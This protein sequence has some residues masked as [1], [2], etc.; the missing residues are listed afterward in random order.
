MPTAQPH[1]KSCMRCIERHFGLWPCS[2]LEKYRIAFIGKETGW[3]GCPFMPNAGEVK[4][5]LNG[6]PAPIEPEAKQRLT[7]LQQMRNQNRLGGW[8]VD[9][10][11]DSGGYQSHICVYPAPNRG[12]DSGIFLRRTDNAEQ[13]LRRIRSVFR[14]GLSTTQR[15]LIENSPDLHS[16]PQLARTARP[17]PKSRFIHYPQLRPEDC[18]IDFNGLEKAW[19]RGGMLIQ[20]SALD[21]FHD[22]L[23]L[24]AMLKQGLGRI[25]HAAVAALLPA[26]LGP[27]LK[28]LLPADQLGVQFALQLAKG[29]A[30]QAGLALGAAA[31]G[32]A[33]GWAIGSFVLPGLGGAAGAAAGGTLA[34]GLYNFILHTF[35]IVDTSSQIAEKNKDLNQ[36]A[37]LAWQGRQEEATEAF[38]KVFAAILLAVMVAILAKKL[39]D[40]ARGPRLTREG[41]EWVAR[42]SRQGGSASPG[43]KPRAGRPRLSAAGLRSFTKAQ[44]AEVGMLAEEVAAMAKLAQQGYYIAIRACNKSRLKW[45]RSGAPINGKPLWLPIKSLN[46]GD[47]DGLVGFS[48]VATRNRGKFKDYPK[49]IAAMKKVKP[50]PEFQPAFLKGKPCKGPYELPAGQGYDFLYNDPATNKKLLFL[51]VGDEFIAVDHHG[52]PFIPD[53]DVTVIQRRT[54]GGGYGPPGHNV[55]GRK[56]Y[57]HGSDAPDIEGDLNHFFRS[58]VPYPPGYDPIQ[59]G[60]RGGSANYMKPIKGG[61]AGTEF[62]PVYQRPGWEPGDLE[63][64]HHIVAADGLDGYLGEAM[65]M[66]QLKQFHEANPMGPWRW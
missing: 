42:Q 9:G 51:K 56:D 13:I 14:G 49:A 15:G 12:N 31:L 16:L 65:D 32:S 50:G 45:L 36:A 34:T 23:R 11:P 3:P 22:N 52:R 39:A 30:L 33:A 26:H 47:F 54:S 53:L 2:D 27:A 46:F 41:D 4:G 19:E 57:A 21:G 40:R 25:E 62:E 6:P 29:I 17:A 5:W 63:E 64:G 48:A 60:G 7:F 55:M 37:T 20:V 66:S 28:A 61:P 8:L 1:L 59:H 24:F 44:A 43:S 38:A 35:D 58:Q 18:G 10:Q